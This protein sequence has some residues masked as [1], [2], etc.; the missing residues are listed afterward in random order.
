MLTVDVEKVLGE[1]A[2]NASFVSESGVTA[3]FGPSGA[4]KTTIVNMI[5]GLLKPDRGKIA[6]DGEAIFDG[7]AD[8]NI[9]AWRR[10][11][12]TVFQEGRLFPHL[13]VRHNLD[14]GRWMSSQPADAAAFAHAAEY[15]TSAICST[16]GPAS[17]RAASASA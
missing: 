4:G 12:G 16:G 9:P 1:F 3:L 10:R 8:L 13:S 15:S 17:S 2:V 14:Y 5:A 6:I 7:A 11:I